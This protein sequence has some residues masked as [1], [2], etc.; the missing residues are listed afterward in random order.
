MAVTV[1]NNA[2]DFGRSSSDQI[3]AD[4]EARELDLAFQEL[5]SSTAQVRFRLEVIKAQ[6]D[7]LLKETSSAV[8]HGKSADEVE[9][10]PSR[11]RAKTATFLDEEEEKKSKGNETECSHLDSEVER[12]EKLYAN[13]LNDPERFRVC[14]RIPPWILS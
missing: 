3:A 11:K 1:S 12:V 9:G 10:G 8:L 5:H 2:F 13:M 7:Y 4:G 14:V 6:Q